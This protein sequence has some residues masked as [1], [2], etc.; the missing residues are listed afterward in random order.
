MSA[1]SI[2]IFSYYITGKKTGQV[3]N[4]TLHAILFSTEDHGLHG[5]SILVL[6]SRVIQ[7]Y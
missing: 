1:N 3:Y 5:S 7:S 4:L 6:A 2:N